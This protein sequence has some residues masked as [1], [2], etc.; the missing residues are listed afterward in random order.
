[1]MEKHPTLKGL[2]AYGEEQKGAI[3]KAEKSDKPAP[4]K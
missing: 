3:K 4:K 2:F 1:M